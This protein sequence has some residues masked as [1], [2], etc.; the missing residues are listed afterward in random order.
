[1]NNLLW[2]LEQQSNIQPP[3][4]FDKFELVHRQKHPY[5]TPQTV[6]FGRFASMFQ[7]CRQYSSVVDKKKEI[8]SN[9]K[10]YQVQPD[11]CKFQIGL[12]IFIQIRPF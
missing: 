12:D 10:I 9:E 2:C 7:L 8:S 11:F 5:P 4:F 3:N 1:M 6:P